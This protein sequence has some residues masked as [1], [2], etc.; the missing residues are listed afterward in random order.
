VEGTILWV[1]LPLLAIGIAM[2]LFTLWRRIHTQS[3]PYA[4]GHLGSV[5]GGWHRTIGGRWYR[6]VELE[7]GEDVLCEAHAGWKVANPFRGGQ[8]KLYLTT[9]RLIWVTARFWA[10]F[11]VLQ[12]SFPRRPIVVVPVEDIL[13]VDL[14]ES[15]ARADWYY[16]VIETRQGAHWFFLGPALDHDVLNEKFRYTIEKLRGLHETAG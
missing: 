2:F 6:K 7:E 16:L 11:P 12:P 9:K 4:S 14:R 13:G 10:N 3:V 5:G 15:W 1:V 8:G